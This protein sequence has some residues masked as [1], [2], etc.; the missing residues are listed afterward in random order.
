MSSSTDLSQEA[1]MAKLKAQLAEA[2]LAAAQAAAEAAR[3]K[4]EALESLA[5]PKLSK[6]KPSPAPEAE[7]PPPVVKTKP[8]TP[9]VAAEEPAP[10]IETAAPVINTA[11]VVKESP[12][13]A[14]AA[15]VEP[16]AKTV[17]TNGATS[18]PKETAKQA[19]PAPVS[20]PGEL[21]KKGEE[22]TVDEAKNRW[23]NQ[24][25]NILQ[26]GSG[27]TTSLVMHAVVLILLAMWFLPEIVKEDIFEIITLPDHTEEDIEELTTDLTAVEE[28]TPVDAAGGAQSIT[29]PV[30]QIQTVATP[31]QSEVMEK[32]L[33]G[34]KIRLDDISAAGVTGAQLNT[35]MGYN[36]PG[37][38]SAI[39]ENYAEAMDRIT[40][41]IL[42]MLERNKV[43]V[44]WLFDES[45][46]MKD[47]QKEIRDRIEKVY[48]ELGL[49]SSAQGDKLLTS[50]CSYGSTWKML[51]KAP[52]FDMNEVRAAIDKVPDDP[53]GQEI[54][55]QAVGTS[56]AFHRKFA[57]QGNRELALILVTDESGNA[58]DNRKHVEPCIA[59]AK[60]ARCRVYVLGREAVFG[61]P[62]AHMRWQNPTTKLTFWLRIDRGPESPEVEQLQ[63]NGFYH[64]YDAHPSGFGPYE[65]VR[66]ARETNGVFF[67]LPSLETNLVRGEKRQYE[68][69][70][71]RPYL[72]DL[73]PRDQYIEMRAKNKLG[74]PLW[75][76][77][78]LLNPYD[79]QRA[80]HIVMRH[81]FSIQPAVFANQ[82]AAEQN[83]AKQYFLFLEQAIKLL[84]DLEPV[85]EQEADP[86]WQAN[87]DLIYAQLVA[88]KIRLYEYGAYMEKFKTKPKLITNPLGDKKKTTH[89][90][91]RL[92]GAMVTGDKFK[93][94]IEKANRLFQK[95]IDEHPGTPW[96]ARAAYEKKRGYGVDLVEDYDD[97]RRSGPGI[98]LPN[99]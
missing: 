85:R 24:A 80:K 74:A 67:M 17:A 75:E 15:V 77:I 86:R 92:A 98:K 45:E 72:P 25:P 42:M 61:Y 49:A 87:Y 35:Y 83:K 73:G 39:V 62:Y 28:L 7:T 26:L 10:I 94:D 71:M 93:D 9:P 46:S 6:K 20:K 23:M 54:M 44:I 89:W 58:E 88:Y 96:A 50:V 37:E 47:D 64:R 52:T 29:G 34:P 66:L 48:Q 82:I 2:K 56:I 55:C 79:P 60:S 51:T 84:Q 95:V 27:V 65:Q 57:Q 97:P 22:S 13:P 21:P 1:E 53:T 41:E 99:L 33:D 5:A 76:I 38:P 43:L 16:A 69:E 18:P 11:P 32:S 68:L 31:T 36:M 90:E 8:A 59:E 30:S 12:K 40:Q 4:V 63:T 70:A 91:L 14:P 3:L 81:H 19:T 78:N